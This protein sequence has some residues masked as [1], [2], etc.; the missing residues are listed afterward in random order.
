MA[1]AS[2]TV[3]EV[4]E[5]HTGAIEVQA[6]SGWGRASLSRP[7]SS[8][9]P[10][11][12]SPPGTHVAMML[13][14]AGAVLVFDPDPERLL[15]HEIVAALGFEP[16]G[17]TS[18][19]KMLKRRSRQRDGFDAALILHQ[20]SDTALQGGRCTLPRRIFRLSG[21]LIDTTSTLSAASLSSGVTEL[22]RYPL[23]STELADDRRPALVRIT[24]VRADMRS[25]AI[26][27]PAC[28]SR[29]RAATAENHQHNQEVK[30][31]AQRRCRARQGRA[32]ASYRRR[33][34]SM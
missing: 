26:T 17:F 9:A 10:H 19:V 14:S 12:V 29:Q 6:Q 24:T 33:S 20:T 21:N 22:V 34:A 2:A 13:I 16:I 8:G 3:R 23:T 4:V 11:V 1:S 18:C 28:T 27:A 31:P 15:R 25:G 30:A 7:S 32:C 5:D